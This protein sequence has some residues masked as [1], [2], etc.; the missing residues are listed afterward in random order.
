MVHNTSKKRLSQLVLLLLIVGSSIFWSTCSK[1]TKIAKEEAER[2]AAS[3]IEK[4]ASKEGISLSQFGEHRVRYIEQ[5][6]AW[7]IYWKSES[8]P[9]HHVSILIDRFRNVEL[10]QDIEQIQPTS[11]SGK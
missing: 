4:Y 6:D 8:K 10:L 9:I 5:V 7:E 1:P 3:E 2:I 11:S